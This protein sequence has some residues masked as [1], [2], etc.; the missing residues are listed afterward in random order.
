[1]ADFDLDEVKRIVQGELDAALG[2]DGGQLS[3]ERL[4]ALQYYNGEPLGTE[5]EG[6][7][8]VVMRSVLEAV[9][10]VLPALLRI[11]TAS[12]QICV[13]EPRLPGQEEQAEIATQY[14]N[15]IWSRDNE[16]FSIL[17]DWMKDALLE[18]TGWLKVWFDTSEESVT[19][20]YTH[21]TE[22]E[23]DALLEQDGEVDVLAKRTT[24]E[25]LPAPPMPPMGAMGAPMPGM[26]PMGPGGPPMPPGGPQG[27]LAPMP[28]QMMMPQ[29][30]PVR[31]VDCT[32]EVTRPKERV[33]IRNC[34]P[35]EILV[36]RRSTRDD[37]P[38]LSHRTRRTYSDLVNDGYDPES[39]DELA[40]DDAPDW[41]QERV[42]RHREDADFP[43]YDRSDAA[44]EIWVE[45]SY[46]YLTGEDDEN[47][48]DLYKVVT[49]G[50]GKFVLTKDGE[51]DIEPVAELPFF[52]ITPIPMP[53]KLIGLS[54]ADLT[55][56]LQLVKSTLIRQMLDNGYL[57]NWPRTEVGD[58]VCNE[59]TYDDLLNLR[60]GAIIRT[61]RVGGIGP[62]SI[63]Y[64]AD[65]TFPLVQYLDETQEVRTGVA[66][67]N[68]GI[69]PDDLNK[70]ATGIS[71]M[72]QA[73]AQ[74]VELF[75]RIFG[76]GLQKVLT[77]VLNLVRRHQTQQRIIR[78]TGKFLQ[79]DPTQWT[80][81]MP[82]TVSVGLGTGNRDQ[83]LAYLMQILNVQQQIVMQQG[84]LQGP[85]LYSKNVYDV[86]E[87]LCENAGFKQPFFADPSKPPDPKMMGPPQQEKPDPA[88][89]AMQA[90]AMAQVQ[91]AQ[92]KAQSDMAIA[93]AKA[94]IQ[95][96]LDQRQ[97]A[98]DIQIAQI[99]A[100]NKLAVEA[101]QAQADM[102][103]ARLKAENEMQ[104]EQMRAEQKAEVAALEVRLK[105]AAGAYDQKPAA[106]PNGSGSP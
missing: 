59:N 60:P 83:I 96:D 92:A 44:R 79:V 23:F 43:P 17:H 31:F 97:A 101:A 47:T 62:I 6:R 86:L 11:F 22:E 38:F 56:D 70:T 85:L 77:H 75:A 50:K 29:T 100:Q 35:E 9:E 58:D 49:S 16:G 99:Q 25:Q 61:R 72:Q 91:V 20:S 48:T 24:T 102:A 106:P 42:A 8:S 19:K 7:S 55:M 54:L 69:S 46:L 82:V 89:Q 63:P 104:V 53:H 65:K 73:A 98:T 41:N 40:P 81:E 14:L 78:V 5:V 13:V 37:I 30:I 36:S 10:W 4:A 45:E 33:I 28:P 105:Y 1:M 66:R 93:Q 32:I 87:K 15:F 2:Q 80:E 21:I 26:G 88:A 103:V 3:Q 64:T 39:L 27:P 51:P 74:R 95:A 67:H 84:G 71:L 12:D 94:Q 57:S 34:P 90:K 68:Q 18:K 52:C 76:S